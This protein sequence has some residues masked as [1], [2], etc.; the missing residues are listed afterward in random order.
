MATQPPITPAPGDLI[1]SSGHHR[2]SPH[3]KT[4]THTQTHMY[5]HVIK[6]THRCVQMHII[7]NKFFGAG[8]MTQVFQTLI[9]LP[10]DLGL[11]LN[12][13]IMPYNYL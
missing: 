5:R 6:V 7:E 8:E 4:W 1:P 2:P 12:T 10:E 3:S 11:I 9:A 13:H